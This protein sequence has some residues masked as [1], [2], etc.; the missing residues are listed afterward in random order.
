VKWPPTG[1]GCWVRSTRPPRPRRPNLAG[2]Y[3]QAGRTAE[4]ITFLERVAAETVQLLGPEHPD[5]RAV[6]HALWEWKGKGR[7]GEE[8]PLPHHITIGAAGPAG[9]DLGDLHRGTRDTLSSNTLSR[10]VVS[11]W[12]V[13][14]ALSQDGRSPLKITR[15]ARSR[16]S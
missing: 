4:A 1:F 15:R 9:E 7:C 10:M 2:S 3:D 13:E 16:T 8:W 14:D 12:E 5:A 6:L 11:S